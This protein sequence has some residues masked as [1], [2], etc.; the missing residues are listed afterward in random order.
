[1]TF[2]AAATEGHVWQSD[3]NELIIADDEC[4][5]AASN[6]TKTEKNTANDG[7]MADE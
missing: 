5:S 2:L 3:H 4:R 6:H 1:M 7:P